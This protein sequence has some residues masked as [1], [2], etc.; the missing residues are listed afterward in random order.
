MKNHSG[1]RR[2]QTKTVHQ[3]LKRPVT[4]PITEPIIEALQS[5]TEFL[6]LYHRAYHRSVTVIL[7]LS[8]SLSPKPI[9]EFT[10][11]LQLSPNYHPKTITEFTD[12]AADNSNP[13]LSSSGSTSTPEAQLVR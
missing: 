10:V 4:E 1:I 7:Q 6:K 9:T 12:V 2:F 3:S 5:I 8:S 11:I 13:A